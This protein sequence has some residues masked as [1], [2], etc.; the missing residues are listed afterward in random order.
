[1]WRPFRTTIKVLSLL[2]FSDLHPHGRLYSTFFG[3]VALIS[4]GIVSA[5]HPGEGLMLISI[6]LA[7]LGL[8]FYLLT[9]WLLLAIKKSGYPVRWLNY[10]SQLLVFVLVL[11]ALYSWSSEVYSLIAIPAIVA[12]HTI[13]MWRINGVEIIETLTKNARH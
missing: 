2:I 9:L 1:M 3:S 6:L 13:A 8:F 4:G 5:S 10:K 11:I 7:S 12:A